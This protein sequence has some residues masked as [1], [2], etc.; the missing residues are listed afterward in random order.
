[1]LRRLADLLR[2]EAAGQSGGHAFAARLG[3]EE[4]VLVMPETAR[5][6]A[7]RHCERIRAQVQATEWRRLAA[8]LEVTVSIGVAIDPLGTTGGSDL[9]SR[10]DAALYEAKRR[11]RNRVAVHAGDETQGGSPGAN[12]QSS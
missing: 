11:G 1:V 10:A 7:R 12:G 8:A 6:G 2:L 3:G 4:F 5:D 9:L